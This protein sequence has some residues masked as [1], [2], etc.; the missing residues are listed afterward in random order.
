MFSTPTTLKENSSSGDDMSVYIW[1]AFV[2]KPMGVSIVCSLSHAYRESIQ[3]ILEKVERGIA[4]RTKNNNN[5]IK[6]KRNNAIAKRGGVQATD[7]YLLIYYR[8]S[9]LRYK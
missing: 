3:V 1:I 7:R 6:L 8:P 9:P 2:Y 5:K 4:Y